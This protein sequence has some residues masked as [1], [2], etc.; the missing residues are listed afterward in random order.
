MCMVGAK[1]WGLKSNVE[2]PYSDRDR[3]G[4]SKRRVGSGSSAYFYK[5]KAPTTKHVSQ[6]PKQNERLTPLQRPQHVLEDDAPPVHR[7]KVYSY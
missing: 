2:A 1:N 4:R 5:P 3:H 6:R 7:P